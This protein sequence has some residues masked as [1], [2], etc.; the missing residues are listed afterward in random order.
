MNL[1]VICHELPPVG[2]G[3]GNAALAVSREL[4]KSHAVTVLTAGWRGLP[5]LEKEGSLSIVRTRPLRARVEGSSL[6]EL[7]VF[8]CAGTAAALR[9]NRRGRFDASLAFHGTAPAWIG[10]ALSKISGVPYLIALRG[11]DVPGFV[12]E[13]YGRAHRAAGWLTRLCWRGAK[14]VAANSEGLK[15]LADRTASKIGVDV[16]VIPNGVDAGFYRPAPLG[17]E[18]GALKG[19]YAGRLTEQKGLACL[20]DALTGSKEALAGKLRVEII[21][22]G[23]LKASLMTRADR[24]GLGSLVSFSPWLDKEDLRR[25]YQSAHFF[26]MPS[27]EEGMSNAALE[28]MACGLPVLTTDIYGNAGLVED[29]VT[30]LL[31]PP[32]DAPALGRLLERLDAGKLAGLG[33]AARRK[34]ETLGWPETAAAFL[35]A[36]GLPR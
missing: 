18:P 4:A 22:E 28:A 23:P 1:L 25:K 29:G 26:V 5:P 36:L 30:G 15:R 17:G 16:R 13:M 33:A 7:A 12:P 10:W 31:F 32:R 27:V 14:C 34:A 19:I 11:A 20:I 8:A 2:G 6:L 35:A 24:Q 9:L 3:S 21:G